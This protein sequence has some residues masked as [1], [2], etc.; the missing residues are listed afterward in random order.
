MADKGQRSFEKGGWSSNLRLA[1]RRSNLICR[2]GRRKRF[3]P[4]VIPRLNGRL[5]HSVH[6]QIRQVERGITETISKAVPRGDILGEEVPVIDFEALGVVHLRLRVKVGVDVF[7]LRRVVGVVARNGERQ[8]AGRI[9]IT[10]QNLDEAVTGLLAYASEVLVNY[11]SPQDGQRT[12]KTSEQH[13]GN[14]WMINPCLHVDGTGLMVDDDHVGRNVCNR[15]D[16][17]ITR[18]PGSQVLPISNVSINVDVFFS[19]IAVEEDHGDFGPSRGAD[20]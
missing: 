11:V 14:V 17:L 9:V 2:I 20:R 5:L 6:L 1:Q 18:M 4:P 3:F 19:A 10:V 7:E 13:S 12:R 16:E 15:E 8:S